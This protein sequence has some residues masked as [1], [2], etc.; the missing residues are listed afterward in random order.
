MDL[1]FLAMGTT[2][3]VIDRRFSSLRN[4]NT[5]ISFLQFSKWV[6]ENERTLIGIFAANYCACSLNWMLHYQARV[7]QVCVHTYSMAM[8]GKKIGPQ[9]NLR[10]FDFGLYT[11]S[12][13][14]VAPVILATHWVLKQGSVYGTLWDVVGVGIFF[15]PPQTNKAT[16]SQQLGK[17]QV[18]YSAQWFLIFGLDSQNKY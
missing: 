5:F 12:M 9:R 15:L 13:P 8:T 3:F 4:F 10:R 1:K 14:F 16:T 2:L 7:G 6:L 11:S 17:F 18:F